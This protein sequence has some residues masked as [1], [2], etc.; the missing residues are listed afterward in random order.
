MNLIFTS[1]T[2]CCKV[3]WLYLDKDSVILGSVLRGL[4]PLATVNTR[5]ATT[6][7]RS[8]ATSQE[9]SQIPVARIQGTE[10]SQSTF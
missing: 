8:N 10:I 7:H 6:E 4:E 5:I 2:S 9:L 3:M 1:C